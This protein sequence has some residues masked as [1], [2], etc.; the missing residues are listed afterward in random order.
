MSLQSLLVSMSINKNLDI[1]WINKTNIILLTKELFNPTICI[2]TCIYIMYNIYCHIWW[3]VG[4]IE[5][6]SV[7]NGN[8][9]IIK[10]ST[11]NMYPINW[12]VMVL[13]G[14]LQP[15]PPSFNMSYPLKRL[16]FMWRNIL[17]IISCS[18]KLALIIR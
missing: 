11:N 3:N 14:E 6:K 8:S 10:K 18:L 9:F 7:K 2:F 16:R 17:L 13:I 15:S 12:R 1:L 5:W 4:Y